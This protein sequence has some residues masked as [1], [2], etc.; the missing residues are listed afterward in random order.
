LEDPGGRTAINYG[1][2]GVP[3]TFFI[4]SSGEIVRK[5]AGPVS[6]PAMLQTLQEML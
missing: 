6:G 2:A 4:D 3:E 5:I 1:V